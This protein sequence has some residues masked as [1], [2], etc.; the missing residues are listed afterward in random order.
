MESVSSNSTTTMVEDHQPPVAAHP[1]SATATASV[2]CFRVLALPLPNHHHQQ[3]IKLFTGSEEDHP[4]ATPRIE[5]HLPIKKRKRSII[6]APNKPQNNS[7]QV[8][9]TNTLSAP[10]IKDHHLPINNHRKDLGNFAE[11]IDAASSFS[12]SLFPPTKNPKKPIKNHHRW[13]DELIDAAS[14][15]SLSLPTTKRKRPILIG[16]KSKKPENSSIQEKEEEGV[17]IAKRQKKVVDKN[18]PTGALAN[19]HH[20]IHKR[21]SA[22]DVNLSS[23]LL[24]PKEE[25]IKYVLPLMDMESRT[26]CENR[27]GLRVKI[28][29]LDTESGHQLSLRQWKTGS[30]LLNSNWNKEFVKRRSLHEGDTI[31]M[32]WDFENLS[33][34]TCAAT[35]WTCWVVVQPLGNASIVK[36]MGTGWQFCDH[37]PSHKSFQTNAATFAIFLFI[38]AKPFRLQHTDFLLRHSMASRGKR[39]FIII[40]GSS[41]VVIQNHFTIQEI[42]VFFRQ[43]ECKHGY[44]INDISPQCGESAQEEGKSTLPRSQVEKWIE[45]DFEAVVAQSKGGY[46]RSCHRSYSCNRP[47]P[48]SSVTWSSTELKSDGRYSSSSRLPSFFTKLYCMTNCSSSNNSNVS[49]SIPLSPCSS[50]FLLR[51]SAPRRGSGSA[52]TPL[53]NASIVKPMGT[54]WQFCD[55][56]PSHKSFQTNAATFAI[57]LIIIAK[58]FCL[59]HRD[60]LLRHSHVPMASRG[61]RFF[62]IITG[63][64]C[65]FIQNH[66]TIKEIRFFQHGNSFQ[67]DPQRHPIKPVS[68]ANL[69]ECKR[70]YRK[71]DIS[72]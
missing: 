19:H 18:P 13:D 59:Q 14:S 16:P 55:H 47:N 20:L 22:S 1:L 44:R 46:G 62:I 42:S 52:M 66:F 64:S 69:V 12:L 51:Y 57:F 28:W 38:I 37:H 36:P 2:S 4:T 3:E 8:H 31:S 41:C 72:A 58:P 29:D 30:F 24:L 27:G 26:A 33:E 10:T 60:F 25:I 63:S 5:D 7:I 61:K 43:V 6:I 11:L 67:V 35:N 34:C 68:A 40:T 48:Q 17:I 45:V 15:L 32:C 53:G 54:G 65:V 49:S 70:R 23:R 56:H 21:L 50:S 9:Q 71:N 39:F